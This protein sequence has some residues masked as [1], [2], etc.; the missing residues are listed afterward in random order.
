MHFQVQRMLGDLRAPVVKTRGSLSIDS[1]RHFDWLRT[2][3]GSRL[4]AAFV[5][6]V[7]SVPALAAGAIS[8]KKRTEQ[9]A[10]AVE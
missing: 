3:V 6:R 10:F 4:P 8:L 2:S 5:F 7:S 1:C 9:V